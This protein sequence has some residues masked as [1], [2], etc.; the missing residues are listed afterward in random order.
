MYIG[1]VDRAKPEGIGHIKIQIALDDILDRIAGDDPRIGTVCRFMY[2]R[3]IYI[4]KETGRSRRRHQ[5]RIS[6]GIKQH[7]FASGIFRFQLDLIFSS[8]N[9]IVGRAQIAAE[10]NGADR[11]KAAGRLPVTHLFR[12]QKI[13]S[14]I[15]VGSKA[16]QAGIGIDSRRVCSRHD[17]ELCIPRVGRPLHRDGR[18]RRFIAR[19]LDRK[20]KIGRGAVP[21][22]AEIVFGE[23]A[24]FHSN[25]FPFIFNGEGI[26]L[27][28]GDRPRLP[29]R[30]YAR[31][32]EHL[33]D[34]VDGVDIIYL[35]IHGCNGKVAHFCPHFCRRARQ[36]HA[37]DGGAAQRCRA[38]ERKDD[39]FCSC[40]IFTSRLSVC[41][42]A[43]GAAGASA[44]R[45]LATPK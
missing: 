43:W 24:V 27:V 8:E 31:D 1:A 4:I 18:R 5:D 26:F 29:V 15:S 21:V 22:R 33:F 39:L 10:R 13:D 16:G 2:C 25:L 17:A 30:P 11:R 9:G 36:K 23:D 41:R 28:F 19:V 45:A 44:A 34:F 42:T 7:I 6:A 14:Y 37:A 40:H 38:D 3:A 35:P 12:R 20:G 32:G